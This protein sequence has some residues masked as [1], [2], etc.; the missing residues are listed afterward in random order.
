MT[1]SLSDVRI[2]DSLCM[3]LQ[4]IMM[5]FSLFGW[6]SKQSSFCALKYLRLVNKA[7]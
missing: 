3:L 2:I 5:L 7:Q 1:Q 4:I 6:A